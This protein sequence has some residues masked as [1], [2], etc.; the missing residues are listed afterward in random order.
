MLVEQKPSAALTRGVAVIDKLACVG[1][2]CVQVAAAVS[3]MSA[4]YE[5]RAFLDIR[6]LLE[7]Y[8]PG[9]VVG[10][11]Y[12]LEPMLARHVE[13][14]SSIA[15]LL[16]F[17]IVG[18]MFALGSIAC[19]ISAS[20]LSELPALLRAEKAEA[21]LYAALLTTAL[22]RIKRLTQQCAAVKT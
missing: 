1:L 8:G 9:L 10:I 2:G 15:G 14:G 12:L 19:L 22:L 21:S 18:A 7:I 20:E 16:V 11:L 17:H 6:E 13:D 5:N 3:G 4:H